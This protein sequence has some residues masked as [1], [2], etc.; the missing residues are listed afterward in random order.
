M[1]RI[2]LLLATCCATV[3]I[4]LYAVTVH[5]IIS[6]NRFDAHVAISVHQRLWWSTLK[7]WRLPPWFS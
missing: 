4:S 3:R 1:S 2:N 5:C 7:N 6:Y